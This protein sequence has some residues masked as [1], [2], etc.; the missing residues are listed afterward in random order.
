MN[1][2]FIT[3]F[4]DAEGCFTNSI[5]RE[6]AMNLGWS[7]E[8]AF[9]IGL[10]KTDKP[11]LQEFKNFFKVGSISKQGSQSIQFIVRS[12][13]DL[14]VI[15]DNFDK[16]PLITE[17]LLNYKLFKQIFQLKLNKEHLTHEGLGKIV[18]IKATTNRGL[19]P[20]LQLAFPEVVQMTIP[21]VNNKESY[22]PHWLAGFTSGEGCFFINFI[23]TKT[24]FG[25]VVHLVFQLT[26]HSRDEKLMKSLIKYLNC[27]YIYK[28]GEILIF[29]VTKFDDIA[30][31]IIPFF[32]NHKIQGVKAKDFNDFCNAAEIIKEKGHLTLEGLNKI[33]ELKQGMNRQRK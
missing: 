21:L 6:N 26:Q 33:R 19:S 30:H 4:T 31:K 28:I 16:Y 14:G 1:P 9:S 32:K 24:R 15:I 13:K 8:Q 18:A 23:K 25:V 29:K 10:H 12:V 27:G 7:V 3:G 5:R 11:L 17:K 20:E 22:D 2:W